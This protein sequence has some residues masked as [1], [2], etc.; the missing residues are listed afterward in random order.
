V[1]FRA[2]DGVEVGHATT[3]SAGKF[4]LPVTEGLP[5]NGYFELVDPRYVHTVSHL[6]TPVVDHAHR[7]DDDILTLT[8]DGL[9]KLAADAGRTQD[10]AH[11]LVIAQVVD[12]QGSFLSGATVAA[13]PDPPALPTPVEV[14]YS[15]DSPQHTGLPC[16]NGAATDES[17][18][19]AWLFDVP[20][21]PSLVITAMDANGGPHQVAFP[22]VGGP[23]LV[24]TPV[25]PVH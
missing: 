2:P 8:P 25:P 10:P 7:E 21:T 11:W 19:K 1:L 13:R 9:R 12:D 17:D 15:D 3:D 14:C 22:I 23:G 6:V 5:L 16:G 4:E 20:E 18:P 24:F